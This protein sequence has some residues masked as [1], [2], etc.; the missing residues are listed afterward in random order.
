MKIEI[1]LLDRPLGCHQ[2][3]RPSRDADGLMTL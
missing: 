1:D 3:K 2:S